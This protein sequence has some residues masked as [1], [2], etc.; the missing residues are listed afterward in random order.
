MQNCSSKEEQVL[1]SRLEETEK[2]LTQ[3]RRD[4]LEANRRACANDSASQGEQLRKIVEELK[5]AAVAAIMEKESEIEDLKQQLFDARS[6]TQ[7][8]KM[9]EYIEELETKVEK[10]ATELAQETL[11]A[12]QKL[13]EERE[14]FSEK[15][16]QL[17][18]EQSQ[19]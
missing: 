15:L 6:T 2:L 13:Q 3:A 14:S 9:A 1:L 12:Q 10:M 19:E 4:L 18:R 11:S 17:F 16:S 7:L 5:D 8:E